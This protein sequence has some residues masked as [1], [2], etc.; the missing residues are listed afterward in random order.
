MG[1]AGRFLTT[2]ALTVGLV[3]AA[4]MLLNQAMDP[5]GGREWV[6]SR[7]R[8]ISGLMRSGRNVLL[9]DYL[10]ERVLQKWRLQDPRVRAGANTVVLGSSRV[11]S[12]GL[13]LGLNGILNLGV[14]N[15][16]LEDLIALGELA[17]EPKDGKR[18]VIG[19]DPWLFN[20]LS[21]HDQW[22][23]LKP[24]YDAAVTRLEGR[25]VDATSGSPG[26][27]VLAYIRRNLSLH[28]SLYSLKS[29]AQHLRGAD[30]LAALPASD[31]LPATR[32]DKFL[33][34]GS[35]VLG[36]G[37]RVTGVAEQA[38][39]DRRWAAYGMKK[40]R[41]SAAKWQLFSD[42]VHAL[43]QG[44]PVLIWMTPFRPST[45][46]LLMHDSAALSE[47]E[48]RLNRLGESPGVAVVG[49]FDPALAACKAEEFH[50][51][52]HP[53]PSCVARQ[54]GETEAGK[55]WLDASFGVGAR[56]KP[57]Y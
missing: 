23:V 37:S 50:D 47:I 2:G 45:H 39:D 28:R 8:A 13:P 35:R 19:V 44:R 16:S 31:S 12:F 15:A 52:A 55:A 42:S 51:G 26:A 1:A 34:D 9:D 5:A 11:L 38:R 20:D 29:L 4:A 46:A 57:L 33:P 14:S 32:G 25:A 3:C 40:F 49:S 43:A 18:L 48:A 54:F 27:A 30:D 22:V 41:Y 17:L 24:E 21:G 56:P 10:E 53:L 7:E 6:V 36:L